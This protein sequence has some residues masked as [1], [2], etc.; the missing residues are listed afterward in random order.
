M[1]SVDPSL[2]PAQI[3]EA[4][5]AS[6]RRFPSSGADVGVAACRAPNGIEQD[7]CYCTTSTCGAGL[8]DAAAAVTRVLPPASAPTVR[9]A[10]APAVAVGS[11]LTLNAQ[12]ASAFNGRSIVAYHWTI[13]AGA[14]AASLSGDTNAASVTLLARAT[15]RVS[16][17]LTVT[18]SIGATGTSSA[19]IEVQ[20]ATTGGTGGGG[21]GGGLGLGWLA[22]LGAAVWALRRRRAAC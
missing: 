2:T 13:T 3:R 12:D 17:S 15:G 4:L 9:V 5:Q 18:D 20:A 7:E 10:A 6:A 22:G 11:S 19:T 1:L 8:L 16:V 21:G 14:D